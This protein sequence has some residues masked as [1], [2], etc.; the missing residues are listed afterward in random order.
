M[1][2]A[3]LPAFPLTSR[4][5]C[6]SYKGLLLVMITPHGPILCRAALPRVAAQTYA[7]EARRAVAAVQRA[8]GLAQ[9]GTTNVF[10]W[11]RRP[12]VRGVA[13]IMTNY[14]PQW[15]YNQVGAAASFRGGGSLQMGTF[16]PFVGSS[17]A[18]PLTCSFPSQPPN[19]RRLPP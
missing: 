16:S 19:H 5:V 4:R 13:A 15:D 18:G 8:Y 6:K 2:G 3:S 10:T 9:P 11:R 14:I 1:C 12:D 17:I 7:S